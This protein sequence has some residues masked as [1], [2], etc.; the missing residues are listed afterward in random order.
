MSFPRIPESHIETV[1]IRKKTITLQEWPFQ[2]SME[3]ITLLTDIASIALVEAKK[4]GG[5][6]SLKWRVP[7]VDDDGKT[8]MEPGPDGK[9]VVKTELNFDLVLSLVAASSNQ[10]A[11]RAPQVIAA[12]QASIVTDAA[13]ESLKIDTMMGLGE[14]VMLL[15]AVLRVN[16]SREGSLG[17]ALAALLPDMETG[18]ET[19]SNDSAPQATPAPTNLPKPPISPASQG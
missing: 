13:S 11:A 16:F 19:S 12:I 17:K 9:I 1:E 7:V 18:P 4:R 2:A 3:A 8:I 10:L 15:R 6:K 14:V 5:I